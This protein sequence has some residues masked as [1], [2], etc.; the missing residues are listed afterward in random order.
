M[1][2][3][4]T[5]YQHTLQTLIKFFL[6]QLDEITTLSTAISKLTQQTLVIDKD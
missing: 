2:K 1:Y 5:A 6:L 4:Q 3:F